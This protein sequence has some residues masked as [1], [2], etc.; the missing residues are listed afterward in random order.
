[1]REEKHRF[2]FCVVGGGMAGLIAA[3]SAARHGAKVAL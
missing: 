2:D 1:M 3:I